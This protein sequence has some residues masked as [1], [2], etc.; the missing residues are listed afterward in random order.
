MSFKAST[1][2][3]VSHAIIQAETKIFESRLYAFPGP[4]C[5]GLSDYHL[6]SMYVWLCME[7]GDNKDFNDHRDPESMERIKHIDSWP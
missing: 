2:H 4:I 1:V 3:N 5:Y 6:H 7:T